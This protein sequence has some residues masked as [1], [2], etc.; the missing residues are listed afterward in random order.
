M[1]KSKNRGKSSVLI[2]IC[3]RCYNHFDTEAE[4]IHHENL[5]SCSPPQ[6][7]PGRGDVSQS[8]TNTEYPSTHPLQN[9]KIIDLREGKQRDG[10]SSVVW[11]LGESSPI[12]P[13]L[14][15]VSPYAS[16][17]QTEQV[18]ASFRSSPKSNSGRHGELPPKFSRSSPPL[19]NAM[20]PMPDRKWSNG[21]RS[22]VSSVDSELETTI[23][24]ALNE[25]KDL[26]VNSAPMQ[27]FPSTATQPEEPF[28]QVKRTPYINGRLNEKVHSHPGLCALPVNGRMNDVQFIASTKDIERAVPSQPSTPPIS[29]GQR[30]QVNPGNDHPAQEIKNQKSIDESMV[31]PQIHAEVAVR[32]PIS[33]SVSPMRKRNLSHFENIML[34][35]N[36]VSTSSELT[37]HRDDLSVSGAR[38]DSGLKRS[39]FEPVPLSPHVAKRRKHAKASTAFKFSQDVQVAQDPSILARAYR[40]EFLASRKSSVSEQSDASRRAVESPGKC[41][42][43]TV[44]HN[45]KTNVDQD[46]NPELKLE[47]NHAPAHNGPLQSAPR[48]TENAPFVTC[49]SNDQPAIVG[50]NKDVVMTIEDQGNPGDPGDSLSEAQENVMYGA[51]ELLSVHQNT[52]SDNDVDH[53]KLWKYQELGLTTES[54]SMDTKDV[55]TSKA[56]GTAPS[57]LDTNNREV[58]T[59]LDSNSTGRILR[60]DTDISRQDGQRSIF[61]FNASLS[62]GQASD[63]GTN[64]GSLTKFSTLALETIERA[65]GQEE[66]STQ[67]PEVANIAEPPEQADVLVANANPQV[68]GQTVEVISPQKKLVDQ[69]GLTTPVTVF[70]RF[71]VAYPEYKGN[72][73]RFVAICKKINALFQQD[74][75]EHR[76]LWDDFII[77]HTMEYSQYLQTC[78][79]N[80]EDPL[81]YERFYRNEIED[82]RFTKRIV[83][84]NT[85]KEILDIGDRE[86]SVISTQQQQQR[87]LSPQLHGTKSKHVLPQQPP[88]QHLLQSSRIAGLQSASPTPAFN[89]PPKPGPIA[90]RS[91]KLPVPQATV[92]LTGDNDYEE[93]IRSPKKMRRSLPWKET[94]RDDSGSSSHTRGSSKPRGSI[95][96]HP[97]STPRGPTSKGLPAFKETRPA[98]PGSK[99]GAANSSP[100]PRTSIRLKPQFSPKF[101]QAAQESSTHVREGVTFSKPL[102]ISDP[103]DPIALERDSGPDTK[104]KMG[105]KTAEA[106]KPED[107]TKKASW[108]DPDNPFKQFTK[109]YTSVRPAKGNSFAADKARAEVKDKARENVKNTVREMEKAKVQEKTNAKLDD[110]KVSSR[111]RKKVHGDLNIL[112]WHL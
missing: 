92:D 94:T 75:M 74:R 63:L 60:E 21:A 101:G 66:P 37:F 109:A 82:P 32:S 110:V 55:L 93:P 9:D 39:S 31:A 50:N 33:R 45:H 104:N 6:R 30:Y 47:A 28:T 23:P 59:E 105:E 102:T 13:G 18:I 27:R 98:N 49:H 67:A 14:T 12:S 79:E 53:S 43:P 89:S 52:D 73:Q 100:L 5:D 35:S 25:A 70:E 106:A 57:P 15:Y 71:K 26:H 95:P 11:K 29:A 108:K 36:S 97:L 4:I 69:P 99:G 24:H 58:G 64:G 85:L 107:D 88:Q 112:D 77:R 65:E 48:S 2:Y 84:P 17:R 68:F 87:H 1:P 20:V 8:L 3:A 34:R 51:L 42:E 90:A 86:D 91:P 7:G 46:G 56:K 81:P 72:E 54:L 80:A 22:D 16:P 44:Q 96:A 76:S 83:T 19:H 41:S 62:S 103:Q 78:A 40:Q 10:P 38:S 61:P 111:P